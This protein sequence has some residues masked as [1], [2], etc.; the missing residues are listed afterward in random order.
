[1]ISALRRTRRRW[2]AAAVAVVAGA[3]LLFAAPAQAYDVPQF[4][5]PD[6][7]QAPVPYINRA[8]DA[9]GVLELWKTGGPATRAA[10]AAALVGGPE[11]LQAFLDGGQDVPLAADRKQLVTELTERGSV[12][13]RSSA[14]EALASDAASITFLSQGWADTW[15][16][17]LRTA[18]TYF[19]EYGNDHVEKAASD[20]LDSGEAAIEQFVLTGWRGKAKM[21][22][23]QAAFGLVASTNPAVSAAAKTS[24]ATDDDE[25]VAAFL[26]Y[27]QFVAADHH[28]ESAAV[29]ALLQ[30][31]R[32]DIKANPVGAAAVADRAKNAV[33]QAKST[34][35]AARE[36]DAA[37][38][39][40]DWDFLSTQAA[41]RN[42]RD[43]AALAAEKP[44]REAFAKAAK[45][46]PGLLSTLSASGANLDSLTKEARQATL[47][48]ALVGTP[49]VRK[50]AEAALLGGDSAIKSFVTDGHAEAST[51]D[52]AK[53]SAFVADRQRVYQLLDA[54]GSHVNKAADI[55]LGST[56][57][58]D[59]RYFLEFGFAVARE[60]D[61]RILA[62]QTMD[63]AGPELRA[64][65]NVALD[66][67]R[68]DLQAFA[69]VGQFAAAKR[70]ETTAAHVASINGVITELAGLADKAAVDAG[71][72]ADAAKAAEAAKAEGAPQAR[73]GNLPLNV[74][75]VDASQL[76]GIAPAAVP[77][78]PAEVPPV[79]LAVTGEAPDGSS[80]PA[81]EVPE[82]TDVNVPP[83][84]TWP[85]A[86][87]TESLSPEA[88]SPLAAS[89]TGLNG[90]TLGLIAALVLAAA[91]AITFL[92]R[93]KGGTPV[94]TRATAS[95][96][97]KPKS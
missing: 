15:K 14:K 80:E 5:V 72:P 88:A 22:D 42:V 23:R 55:A 19:L 40:A 75:M 46:L 61:N 17:D 3:S 69:S 85:E 27:G 7:A 84:G 59:I 13:V 35:A 26:R 20:S 48:L 53:P 65:A 63:K 90:W 33:E 56:N 52:S 12:H 18:A 95:T 45:E 16:G 86:A 34:P 83:A 68:A 30:Q 32:D 24:L 51:L 50:A 11:T 58:A 9:A 73:G 2:T 89:S 71:Q 25:T 8:A 28:T 92:L 74:P 81:T 54:G 10:A 62:F 91:G 66:G 37:R 39:D 41:P 93:R 21:T 96:D 43:N 1:M 78:P 97:A 64:A 47:D 82:I 77:W 60:L 4:E 87:S 94:P 6:A 44:A 38:L 67:S 29:T 76:T 31:V 49:E 36:A 79:A 70:D 57:H